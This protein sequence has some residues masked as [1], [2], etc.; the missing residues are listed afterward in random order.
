M[1]AVCVIMIVHEYYLASGDK[2][3]ATTKVYKKI[4]SNELKNDRESYSNYCPYE[5]D[6]MNK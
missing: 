3:R 5:N 2:I 6:A 4:N 1:E